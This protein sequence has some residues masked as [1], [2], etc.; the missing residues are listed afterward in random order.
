MPDGSVYIIRMV[1]ATGNAL[2]APPALIKVGYTTGNLEQRRY[3]LNTGNPYRLEYVQS[4]L[5]MDAKEGER[6]ALN[7]LHAHGLEAQPDYRGG[8]EWFRLPVGGLAIA[9]NL[10]GQALA[11]HDLLP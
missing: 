3:S 7:S 6:V 1:Q 9:Q 2:P 11:D 4:W 10:I 8:R 5:V